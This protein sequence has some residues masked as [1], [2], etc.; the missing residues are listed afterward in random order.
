MSGAADGWLVHEGE[1]GRDW[2]FRWNGVTWTALAPLAEGT[3]ALDVWGDSEGNAWIPLRTTEEEQDPATA[4]LHWDGH[5]LAHLAVPASF[6]VGIVRGTTP[7]DVWLFG[8]ERRIYHFDGAQLRQGKATFEVADAWGA[9]DGDL[10]IVGGQ[11]ATD[12]APAAARAAHT[13]PL[14]EVKK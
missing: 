9:P 1:D 13:G 8:P 14:P 12:G 5:T 10:W 4:L 3:H 2:L 11:A 7:R 6:K